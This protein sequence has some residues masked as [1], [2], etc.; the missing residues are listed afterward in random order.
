MKRK[1]IL[2]GTRQIAE[3]AAFYFDRD[4]SY[5]IVAFTVDG[6]FLEEERFCTRPVVPFETISEDYPPAEHDLFVAVSYQKM[7]ALRAAKM[8]AAQ[9]ARY[10]LARYVSSKAVIWDGF[11]PGA[12]SFVMEANVIQPFARVGAGTILWSGNHIGHHSTVGDCCFLA[13]HIVVSGNVRIGERCFIGVNST[14]REGIEIGAETLIGAGSLIMQNTKPGEVYMPKSTPASPV[15]S[16][17]VR[18]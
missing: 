6:A 10:Q 2:F 4:S 14:L 16:H 1:L 15:P 13:S 17:R 8:E 9:Q 18:M 12:N 11:Q 3:V 5:E 7:N